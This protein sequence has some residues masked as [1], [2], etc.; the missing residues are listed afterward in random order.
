MIEIVLASTNPGKVAEI[1]DLVGNLPISLISQ[2]EYQIPPVEE[3]GTTF[4]EN[5][6]IKARH[7]AKYSG[8]PALADDSGLVVHCLGGAPGVY[9]SR[10]AGENATDAD[11][12][13][14][15]LAEI[16]DDESVDRS[17]SFHCVIALIEYEDDPAP[18][19]CHGIWPGEILHEPRGHRG[20]GYDP[21][22]Y[23]PTHNCSAAELDPQE[24]NRISHRGQALA[25]FRAVM[26]QVLQQ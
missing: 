24:K 6:I 26:Y 3:Y 18:L 2:E 13:R 19:I 8:M 14:K 17:A 5:A 23:V 20:F 11:R 1:R 4:V 21:I 12:I 9:S 15:V 16:G 22:F 7:A 10:Y 25:D